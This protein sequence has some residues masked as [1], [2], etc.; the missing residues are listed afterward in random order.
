MNFILKIIPITTIMDKMDKMDKISNQL[1]KLAIDD[2]DSD[3]DDSVINDHDDNSYNKDECY[4]CMFE[5]CDLKFTSK[6]DLTSH[7][8]EH[9][10]D[11]K[12]YIC[13]YPG[14]KR[15]SEPY[16]KKAAYDKHKETAHRENL[17]QEPVSQATSAPVNPV[18]PT[19]YTCSYQGCDKS[20]TDL[21]RY[22]KHVGKHSA[23]IIE[24]LSDKKVSQIASD[25]LEK[26]VNVDNFPAYR[27][28]NTGVA[29]KHKGKALK[30]DEKNRVSLTNETKK[31]VRKPLHRLVATH[32]IPVPDKYKNIPV[33]N[34]N[35]SHIDGNQSNNHVSNLEWRSKSDSA[36]IHNENNRE[37]N[38]VDQCDLDGNCIKTWV[39]AKAAGAA[40]NI[41]W[42]DIQQWCRT[43]TPKYSNYIWKYTDQDRLDRLREQAI[44]DGH[45]IREDIE[46]GLYIPIG[47]INGFDYSQY[48]IHTDGYRIINNRDLSYRSFFVNDGYTMIQ[49]FYGD[50]KFK[51]LTVHKIINQVL[52]GGNYDDIID[53]IDQNR[54]NND[55]NNL[56]AVTQQE[57]TIRAIG[58]SVNQ[59]DKNTKKILR[60]FRTI[61]D[62][63]IYIGAKS[64]GDISLVCSGSRE[65]AYGFRWKYV[66]NSADE[67]TD[68]TDTTDDSD[69]ESDNE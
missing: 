57:N 21:A 48:S 62:A 69:E 1:G 34:L 20:F 45:Q 28:Y 30:P 58:L 35:V 24:P 6:Y 19:T 53:H 9:F 56:E 43:Q 59:L 4:S 49:L 44:I 63:R 14:C 65:I 36:I 32:F 23:E 5:G 13:S 31:G 27:V 47:E 66:N 37:Y 12:K 38:E 40:F 68:D 11:D 42:E 52:K 8:N 18:E 3:N 50:K 41:R 39:S 22:N 17:H 33:D 15:K 46:L 29:R 2:S 10:F 67:E 64:G 7:F 55:I 54:G 25:I 60:T 51:S 16:I 61:E 26:W